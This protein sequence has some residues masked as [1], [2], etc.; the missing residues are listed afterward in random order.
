MPGPWRDRPAGGSLFLIFLGMTVALTPP[1]AGRR[2]TPRSPGMGLGAGAASAGGA[3]IPRSHFVQRRLVSLC[4]RSGNRDLGRMA[5]SGWTAY[6]ARFRS[7]G[8]ARRQRPARRS[9]HSAAERCDD[10]LAVPVR[11]RSAMRQCSQS[12]KSLSFRISF[13]NSWWRRGFYP[14]PAR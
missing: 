5:E 10:A 1:A 4:S 8:W 6:R 12:I 11:V 13:K 14:H 3:D 7:P 2:V 9:A